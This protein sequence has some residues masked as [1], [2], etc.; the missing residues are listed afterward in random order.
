MPSLP[1]AFWP[2]IS[3]I[4][5]FVSILSRL[6]LYVLHRGT[7]LHVPLQTL[8]QNRAA[9]QALVHDRLVPVEKLL[10]HAVPL[11]TAAVLGHG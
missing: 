10:Y 11:M 9:W 3:S 7:L 6:R 4:R 5:S 1:T 8:D 2:T